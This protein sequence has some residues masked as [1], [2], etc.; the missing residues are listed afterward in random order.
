MIIHSWL[1]RITFQK[2]TLNLTHEFADILSNECIIFYF[3]NHLSLHQNIQWFENKNLIE[4]IFIRILIW[5]THSLSHLSNSGNDVIHQ[6][7]RQENV[8]LYVAITLVSGTIL[9][10]M[11]RRFSV[12]DEAD[13][14]RL[15][16][17]EPE[18]NGTL[19]LT[20]YL[21]ICIWLEY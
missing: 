6:L 7:T 16:L 13:K 14:F 2:Q 17:Q 10:Q 8:T 9:H 15:F 18:P 5:R 21:C 19:G 3:N 4:N 12:A 11:Y 20:V 1:S